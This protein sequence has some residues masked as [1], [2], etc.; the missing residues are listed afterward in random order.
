MLCRRSV[1]IQEYDFTIVYR[2]GSSNS[3]ADTL[4]HFQPSLYAVTISLSHTF[5]KD[6]QDSS[7]SKDGALS[8]VLKACLLHHQTLHRIQYE[9]NPHS[10]LYNQIWHQLKVANQCS[11]IVYLQFRDHSSASVF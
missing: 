8:T 7:Q 6:L 10:I 4:S 11:T 5:Y 3:N 9:R 2:M 1:A